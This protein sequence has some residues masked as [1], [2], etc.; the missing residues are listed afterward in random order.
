[1]RLTSISI[2]NYSIHRSTSVDL[3]PVTVLIGRNGGGK[4][5]LIDA[6]MLLSRTARS[7]LAQTFE[8]TGPLSYRARLFHGAP[9]AASMRFRL[10][11]EPE[12]GRGLV[13]YELVFGPDTNGA[14]SVQLESLAAADGRDVFRRERTFEGPRELSELP[15]DTTVLA[16]MRHRRGWINDPDLLLV[17]RCAYALGRMLRF[18]FD[19]YP[20]GTDAP[21]LELPDDEREPPKEPALGMRGENTATFLYWLNDYRGPEFRALQDDVAAIIPG[22][23]GFAFNTARPG[24]VGFLMTFDDDRGTVDSRN[25][26]AGTL[27]VIG[28][29]ALTRFAGSRRPKV[30]C[31]EEPEL[32]LTPTTARGVFERFLGRP[33]AEQFLITSHSPHLLCESLSQPNTAVLRCVPDEDGVA[34]V[35]TVREAALQELDVPGP[36]LLGQGGGI[37]VQTALRL[38]EGLG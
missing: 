32:G 24:R 31:V 9:D 6:L 26:S 4:S 14:L 13:T 27:S 10:D 22:F 16:T 7:S 30:L 2:E 5:A 34:Q 3:E 23:A 21:E 15:D 12:E 18:R 37:G 8:E 17:Q 33:H 35:L 36:M 29:L 28:M 19:P 20:V 38:M 25:L 1:V 11:F